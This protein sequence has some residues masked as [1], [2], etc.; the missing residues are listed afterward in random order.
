MMKCVSWIDGRS[1]V[2]TYRDGLSVV[3][4]WLGGNKGSKLRKHVPYLHVLTGVVEVLPDLPHSLH[5][6]G[7]ACDGEDVYVLGGYSDVGTMDTTWK[8]MDKQHWEQLPSMIHA[9]ESPVCTI[10]KDTIYV[11]GCYAHEYSKL[12]QSFNIKTK[13]WTLKKELPRR[14]DLCHSGVVTHAGKLAV[15]RDDQMCIM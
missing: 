8:L 14:S 7:V 9:V 12:V 10:H 6:A 4:A 11:I 5:S 13:T 1:S 3:D 2:Q 15:I